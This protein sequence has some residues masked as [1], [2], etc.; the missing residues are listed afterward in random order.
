MIR[1]GRRA[2]PHRINLNSAKQPGRHEG[3]RGR[4]F[5]LCR[6]DRDKT[7]HA[8]VEQA[9]AVEIFTLGRR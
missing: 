4:R 7:I 8:Q 6:F 2:S 1:P 3:A 5:D 9:D